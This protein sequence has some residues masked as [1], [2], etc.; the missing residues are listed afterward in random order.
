MLD[1]PLMLWVNLPVVDRIHPQSNKFV[2]GAENKA[3]D[4]SELNDSPA[5]I[6]SKMNYKCL[7][8]E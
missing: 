3:T 2:M 1:F 7:W 8:E 5:D 4:D 6:V